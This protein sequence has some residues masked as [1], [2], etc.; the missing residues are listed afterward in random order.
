MIQR[1]AV[2]IGADMGIQKEG[3]A[4]FE[5]AVGVFEVGLALAN[6]LNFAAAQ[7]DSRLEFVEQEIVMAGRAVH[8]GVALAGGDRIARFRLPRRRCA[9]GMGALACHEMVP[10][11]MLARSFHTSDEALKAAESEPS[12]MLYSGSEAR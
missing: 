1:V 6:G 2:R 10:K 3:L 11:S 4:V 9:N 7:C 5:Q 8:G 12:P